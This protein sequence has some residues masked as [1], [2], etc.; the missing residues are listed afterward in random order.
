M[1]K[2]TGIKLIG[3]LAIGVGAYVL[4]SGQTQ[5]SAHAADSGLESSIAALSK[6]QGV[7]VAD[8]DERMYEWSRQFAVND[9]MPQEGIKVAM[10]ELDYGMKVASK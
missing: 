7:L 1:K 2:L 8:F 3:L 5:L 10:T 9:R 4:Q 6:D